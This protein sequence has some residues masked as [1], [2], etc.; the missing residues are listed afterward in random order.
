MRDLLGGD[1]YVDFADDNA[2]DGKVVRLGDKIAYSNITTVDWLGF[3][4]QGTYSSGALSAYG[5]FGWSQ[6]AYTYQDSFTVAKAVIDHGDAI[7]AT[8]LKGGV[9]YDLND[10]ISLFANYGLVEKPPIM[11]NVIYFDGTVASNP[12]NEKFSSLEGGVNYSSGAMAVKAN[13]YLTKWMD[14]N[15]T[16][17]VT[18][19][20]GSSGDTDVIFLTGVDQDHSGLEVEA[21]MQV[22][23]MLRL[24]AAFGMGN[25]QFVGDASGEYQEAEFDSLGNQTG[26]T[27]TT[28]SYA[29]EGLYVGDMPQTGL[30]FGATLTPL[31]GLS[32][33]ALLNYYDKN[34]SDWSPSAREYS[35]DDSDAD[36]AQVYM[37]PSYSKLNLHVNYDLPIDIAGTKISAFLH[38][39]NALDAVYVQDAVDNSQYNGY[40]IEDDN[41]NVLN[42][43]SASTAEVFLGTPRYFNAGLTVRF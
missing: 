21:S 14:R 33:Q 5:M 34:Y 11:D 40:Y 37:A 1:Y 8:Q 17:S 31:Q 25:W 41:D 23:D 3:F 18:T 35:G 20:Q 43:H 4:G 28:Y 12:E 19:G 6:I 16:K 26:Q 10:N 9:M 15:L 27:S 42:S 30:S 2:P 7:T 36:R 32:I 13:Y 22:I 24:D 38:V 39:F 29:L